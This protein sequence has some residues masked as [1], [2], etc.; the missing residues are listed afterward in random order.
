MTL[1]Q[2]SAGQL[3]STPHN[4]RMI[5]TVSAVQSASLVGTLAVAGKTRNT[6]IIRCT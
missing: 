2:S 1:W 6:A 4:Q 5:I 3:I